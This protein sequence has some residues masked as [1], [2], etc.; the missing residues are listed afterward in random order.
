MGIQPAQ[1]II[2]FT[3]FWRATRVATE[4]VCDGMKGS[5]GAGLPRPQALL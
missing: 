3:Y 1:I 2:L 4:N 5:R